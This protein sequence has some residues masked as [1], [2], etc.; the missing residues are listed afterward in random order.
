LARRDKIGFATPERSW[1]IRLQPWA[2]HVLHSD[3]AHSIAALHLDVVQQQWQGVLTG[4]RAF[5]FRCWRWL[6]V[7]CWAQQF[8]VSFAA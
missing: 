2:N 5:D 6:N 8:Q 1:L 4:Q 7:I 3:T